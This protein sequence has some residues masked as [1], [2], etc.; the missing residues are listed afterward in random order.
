MPPPI[1]LWPTISREKRAYLPVDNPALSDSREIKRREDYYRE[2][3]PELSRDYVRAIVLSEM[4]CGWHVGIVNENEEINE[5]RPMAH[6]FSRERN[7]TEPQLAFKAYYGDLLQI[8]SSSSSIKRPVSSLGKD[9][10][11]GQK[12][13]L[14]LLGLCEQC[15]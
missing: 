15:S 8:V 10:Y 2:L 5:E 12:V 7:W 1:I 3:F 9:H 13:R 4:R 11:H 6:Y 14:G